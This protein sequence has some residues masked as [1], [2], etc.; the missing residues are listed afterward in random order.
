MLSSAHVWDGPR[1]GVPRGDGS[2]DGGHSRCC[3]IRPGS[4]WPAARIG[5]AIPLSVSGAGIPLSVGGAVPSARNGSLD[6]R[7][8]YPRTTSRLL[9]RAARCRGLPQHGTTTFPDPSP[10][11][12]TASWR[13]PH[14]RTAPTAPARTRR[15]QEFLVVGSARWLVDS[16]W[17]PL[18]QLRRV[19]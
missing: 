18:G 11:R 14:L 7:G 4:N 16:V 2:G 15:T 3:S 6:A 17:K 1:R 19:G 12:T 13:R 8:A 5:R 10:I 9:H